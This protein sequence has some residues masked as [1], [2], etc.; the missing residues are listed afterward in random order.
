MFWRKFAYFVCVKSLFLSKVI[1]AKI[2]IGEV[3]TGT[4]VLISLGCAYTFA[5]PMQSKSMLLFNAAWIS[6]LLYVQK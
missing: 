6:Q 4:S 5:T 2:C 3:D 1:S